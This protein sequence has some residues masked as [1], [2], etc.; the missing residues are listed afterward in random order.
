MLDIAFGAAV[1]FMV[2]AVLILAYGTVA[3]NGFGIN[4]FEVVC[5]ICDTVQPRFRIPESPEQARW[6]GSR[7]PNCSTS[8][9]K[10]GR[11]IPPSGVRGRDV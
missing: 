3:K 5:P 2:V 11:P 9:D 4:V 10:W 8:L 7:C 1:A 6:G